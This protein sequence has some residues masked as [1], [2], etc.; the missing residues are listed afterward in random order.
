[1]SDYFVFL[2]GDMLVDILTRLPA[3]TLVRCTSVCKSW[4][5]LITNPSFITKHLNR[6]KNNHLLLFR[7][8][9][10]PY[11]GDDKE[12]YSLR[13]DDV[14][15]LEYAELDLPLKSI[16]SHYFRII[17]STNGLI[18]LSDDQFRYVNDLF[19]WN[20]SIRKVFPLPPVRVTFQ[21]HGPFVANIGFGF[22]S[23]TDDYK[24]IRIVHFENDYHQPPEIDI[25][26]LSTALGA[27]SVI[28]RFQISTSMS[29]LPR[30][31]SRGLHTGLLPQWGCTLAAS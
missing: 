26:S 14:R 9:T 11:V 21:S 18:C 15:F 30:L 29:W 25:F 20:P 8:H 24:V 13:Y 7:S 2:P 16:C 12:H 31:F 27:T 22:D 3:E 23:I 5:S 19:L 28:W 1:M 6:S 10:D 4:Y 17:G